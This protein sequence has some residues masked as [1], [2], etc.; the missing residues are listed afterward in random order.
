M[1]LCFSHNIVWRDY[2]SFHSN[3]KKSISNHFWRRNSLIEI[4]QIQS[5]ELNLDGI[6]KLTRTLNQAWIVAIQCLN[7]R[8]HV[9][10]SKNLCSHIKLIIS[11]S[12]QKYLSNKYKFS[13]KYGSTYSY[14]VFS[15]TYSMPYAVL[16]PLLW[17]F[18]LPH[19]VKNQALEIL[20]IYKRKRKSIFWKDF[21][22]RVWRKAAYGNGRSA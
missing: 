10:F 13:T 15:W 7:A 8:F 20:H 2:P 1:T 19:W 17:G 3:R 14:I 16:F 4:Y 22:M 5:W 11:F 6:W 21:M 18:H 9:F 12:R